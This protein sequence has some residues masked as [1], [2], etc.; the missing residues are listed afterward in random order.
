MSC[1]NLTIQGYHRET[2]CVILTDTNLLG[3][4]LVTSKKRDGLII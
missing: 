2:V 3:S 1:L 4:P